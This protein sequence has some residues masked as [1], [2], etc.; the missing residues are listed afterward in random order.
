MTPGDAWAALQRLVGDWEGAGVGEFPTIETFDYRETLT[1]RAL[2]GMT[3]QYA[4]RTW[5][6]SAAEYVASH[7]EIGYIGVDDDGSIVM[8]SAHGLDRLEAMRG[9]LHLLPEG[10]TLDLTST[11][12]AHDERMINSWRRWEIRGDHFHHDMGM[13]TTS[14]PEGVHHLSADLRMSSN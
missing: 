10:L 3:L 9:N 6:R 12:L 2:G 5:R 7:Q 14:T 4:Q 11:S 8:T 13:A 1:V